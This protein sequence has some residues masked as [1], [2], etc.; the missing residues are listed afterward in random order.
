[1]EA[2]SVKGDLRCFFLGR[3]ALQRGSKIGRG[4]DLRMNCLPYIFLR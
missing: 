3:R 2:L 1:M 4:F